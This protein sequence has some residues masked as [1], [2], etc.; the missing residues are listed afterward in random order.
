MTY[1]LYHTNL[2]TYATG[3]VKEVAKFGE[4]DIFR[5]FEGTIAPGTSK[6]PKKYVKYR[7]FVD[8]MQADYHNNKYTTFEDIKQMKSICE[9][10]PS[11]KERG[12]W[13]EHHYKD[14]QGH[15][16]ETVPTVLPRN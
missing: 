13:I 14:A 3:P 5:V 8:T 12:D 2:N 11:E 6:D 15:R 9:W 4:K 16:Q 7:Y 10:K 1:I